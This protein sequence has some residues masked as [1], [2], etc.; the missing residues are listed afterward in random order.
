MVY[1]RVFEAMDADKDTCSDRSSSLQVQ[2]C[3][4]ERRRSRDTSQPTSHHHTSMVHRIDVQPVRHIHMRSL[5]P[6]ALIHHEPRSLR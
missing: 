4:H 2:A 6:H 5:S 1:Q 3:M